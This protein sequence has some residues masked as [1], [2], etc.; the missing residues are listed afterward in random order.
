M[1]FLEIGTYTH[2]SIENEIR[3]EYENEVK[4]KE[5]GIREHYRK[6]KE[7]EV[8]LEKAKFNSKIDAIKMQFK[9]EYE[10]QYKEKIS[11][12]EIY[13]Q[14]IAKEQIEMNKFEAKRTLEV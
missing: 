12:N 6:E 3:Q 11:E 4:L 1:F 8:E 9:T 14:N 10:K 7:L 13:N 5:Q 2:E